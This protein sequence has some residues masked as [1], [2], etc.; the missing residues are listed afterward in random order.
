MKKWLIAMAGLTLTVAISVGCTSGIPT[1]Y[2]DYHAHVSFN[3]RTK[4]SYNYPD[5][6]IPASSF[7]VKDTR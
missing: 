6:R 4:N 1:N 2:P 3:G 5:G 7:S